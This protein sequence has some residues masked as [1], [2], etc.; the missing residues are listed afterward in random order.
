MKQPE[1]LAA[2][3]AESAASLYFITGAEAFLR[4]EFLAALKQ[5]LVPPEAESMNYHVFEPGKTQLADALALATSP[6]FFA[7]RRLVVLLHPPFLGGGRTRSDGEAADADS[8]AFLRYIANPLPSTCLAVI[9][10]EPDMRRKLTKELA[11]RAA[12]V[13]C[14]PLSPA[15]AVQWVEQRGARLY[16][17]LQPDAALA[18]VERAGTDLRTLDTELQKLQLYAAEPEITLADV[19]AVVVGSAE[20]EV[21][22]LTDAV[23]KKQSETALRYLQAVLR[24]VDHPLQLLSALANQYR[25]LLAI[26]SLSRQRVSPDEGARRLKIHPYRYKVLSQ[27]V[28]RFPRAELHQAFSHLLEADLAMKSG[29]DPRLVLEALVMR[30]MT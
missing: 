18:L 2:L 13:E 6:P 27:E 5:R 7:A 15:D 22:K 9:H 26:H 28:R 11:K 12:V 20:V 19:E 14:S 25:L 16:K 8:A 23:I 17:P 4:E 10:P 21:Y 30:L 3:S 29:Q 1:A 24:Q